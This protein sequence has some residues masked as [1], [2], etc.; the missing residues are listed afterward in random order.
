MF[1]K[2]L[3]PTRWAKILA[4]LGAG[5]A[6]GSVAVAATVQSETA[7][8]APPEP[9]ITPIDPATTTTMPSVSLPA[10]PADGL[11]VIR[12]T[13]VPPPAP[14]V[15]VQTVTV[16]GKASGAAP[17]PKVKSSGS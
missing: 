7:E 8:A 16:P 12:Y 1:V 2:R 17:A 5:L 15:I 10:Q 3:F 11:V 9:E 14:Q 4:W 13:A 6:W